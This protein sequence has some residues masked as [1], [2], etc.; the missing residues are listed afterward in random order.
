MACSASVRALPSVPFWGREQ[1]SCGGSESR[2]DAVS[3]WFTQG[4]GCTEC[5]G[6][7]A[8][9]GGQCV[10]GAHP[11]EAATGHARGAGEKVAHGRQ[12]GA[13]WV[14]VCGREPSV[15]QAQ[16]GAVATVQQRRCFAWRQEGGVGQLLPP[17]QQRR[18]GRG[19]RQAPVGLRGLQPRAAQQADGAVG[20]A[21]AQRRLHAHL[22]G[23]DLGTQVVLVA[24]TAGVPC[25]GEQCE[26]QPADEQDEQGELDCG[27]S[28]GGGL[29]RDGGGGGGGGELV[30][31]AA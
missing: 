23:L 5:E 25:R 11:K 1:K 15:R 16:D 27:E 26:E 12:A 6:G 10:C 18:S 14:R 4:V 28:A 2:L 31:R 29:G 24:G 8:R 21:R 19:A 9:G 22:D 3:L 7:R 20:Q 17:T 13:G 30:A